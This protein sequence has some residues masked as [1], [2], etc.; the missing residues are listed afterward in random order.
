VFGPAN[1]CYSA[2]SFLIE[3]PTKI[4]KFYEGLA[5]L[6]EQISTFLKQFKI[7]ER[8]QQFTNMDPELKRTT[9]ELMICFVDICALSIK[10]LGGSKWKQIKAVAK[11]ILF[12]NDSGVNSELE[13]FKRLVDQ[14]SRI[15]DAVTLE[16]VLKSHNDL[17]GD[18]K[19]IVEML[20]ESAEQ[21]GRDLAIISEGVDVLVTEVNE[22]K[23]QEVATQQIERLMKMLSIKPEAAQASEKT[24]Q[25]ISA[26]SVDES[27]SWIRGIDEYRDWADLDSKSDP[28]FLLSGDE[29]SGKSYLMSAIVHE[30]KSQYRGSVNN[31]T[32]TSIA[33][34]Y[35]PTRDKKVERDS[36]GQDSQLPTTALKS[37]AIQIAKQNINY[38]KEMVKFWDGKK[39]SYVRDISCKDLC[40]ALQ[41]FEPKKDAAYILLFDGLEQL[42]DNSTQQLFEVLLGAKLP[43]LRI[44]ASAATDVLDKCL[45]SF[46]K[47]LSVRMVPR[48]DIG[49]HNM[50]DIKQYI[51]RELKTNDLLQ[52]T[53]TDTIQLIDSIRGKLPVAAE[54]NFSR[55][56]RVLGR[57]KEAISADRSVED[58]KGLL[59]EG[60]LEDGN[61]AAQKVVSALNNSL[62]DQEIDQLNE[63]LIWA[64]HGYRYFNVDML[65]AA[66]F[67]RYNRTPLQ[68]LEK[69]LRGKYAK[70]FTIDSDGDVVVHDDIENLF[71]GSP[72]PRLGKDA[73]GKD[74]PQI[75]M[76]IT[77]N[78]ADIEMVRRFFWDLSE[79]A[80]FRTFDFDKFVKDSGDQMKISANPVDA[81]FAMTT[82]CLKLLLN[83]PDKRTDCLIAY[84]LEQL[85]SHLRQLREYV[86]SGEID[87][88]EKKEIGQ[89][90]VSLFL[91]TD[92]IE[93]H[94]DSQEYL[95]EWF[96]EVKT[97]GAWVRDR[98]ATGSL[99][100]EYHRWVE[101]VLS[102]TNPGVTC[103]K[104][105]THMVAKR[106]LRGKERININQHFEWVDRFISVVRCMS[107][108]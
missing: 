44:I 60:S 53:E 91:Y 36:V 48:I 95:T 23:M 86:D 103:L 93:K 101:K 70:V 63:L 59:A 97:F 90:L 85:P 6:F 34:Y 88:S 5:E 76:T 72:S 80:V 75:S 19:K 1:L 28:L 106:W 104:N 47:A 2:A 68:P 25:E 65:K 84:A 107:P 17:S 16:H 3:I 66:L 52:G 108:F 42:A 49:K 54:G 27:G 55:V 50:P 87:S 46:E 83:E 61:A 8:I 78:Q 21:S 29:K 100:L 41:L 74:K 7:Y 38:A 24:F 4:N 12:D 62:N 45:S 18:M 33:Y 56:Q 96:E 32:R 105:I 15:S 77:I 13:K 14:Q 30:L 9:H 51:E 37:M 64:I 99:V 92:S 79:N 40:S 22:R 67:L 98:E 11:V 20:N 35:F 71:R 94:W 57:I 10:V 26:D 82:Q 89:N 81:H 73:D 43:K 69:K 58:I 31:P 39:E 102:S